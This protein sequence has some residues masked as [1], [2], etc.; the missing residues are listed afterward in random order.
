MKRLNLFY[1]GLFAVISAPAF[2]QVNQ[3]PVHTG[4]NQIAVAKEKELAATGSMYVNDT[5]LPAKLSNNENV[6]L[7]RYNAYG[8]YFEM[9]NPQEQSV[10][11]LPL[12]SGVKINFTGTGEEYTVVNYNPEKGDAITGYLNIIA[13]NS[14]IKIY[15]RERVYLQPGK[16]SANSYQAAK[17]PVYKR[18]TDE[19]YVQAGNASQASFFDGKKDLAKLIPG[20]EKEVLEY[21]KKNNIDIEK[22]TDLQK[23]AAYV[24]TIL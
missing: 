14:K 17:A 4:G 6:V 23:L 8:D 19:F 1:A 21:I 7:L 11:K 20:K 12:E 5:Y 18:A 22:A 10:K 15:K 3:T 9:N 16:T 2:A 13:D 24:E